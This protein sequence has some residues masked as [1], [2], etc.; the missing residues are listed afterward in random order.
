LRIV[1]CSRDDH[2]VA[3]STSRTIGA[4][5]L[6]PVT[7]ATTWMPGRSFGDVPGE[8][9][10][11]CGRAGARDDEPV[12]EGEHAHRG[13]QRGLADRDEGVAALG[14]DRHRHAALSTPPAIPSASVGSIGTSTAVPAATDALSAR[15]AA[16]STPTTRTSARSAAHRATPASSPPPPTGTATVTGPA[17][18]AS[19]SAA[20]PA[21]AGDD[22]RIV[23]LAHATSNAVAIPQDDHRVR[24][25]Q[26]TPSDECRRPRRY[27]QALATDRH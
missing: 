12:P 2:V 4:V 8:H 10:S 5:T 18:C 11:W 19:S 7:S 14:S 21:L 9:G 24:K 23:V 13:A 20:S 15:D 6:R 17:T 16:A 26:L 22:M 25:P 27:Q 1:I 3:A